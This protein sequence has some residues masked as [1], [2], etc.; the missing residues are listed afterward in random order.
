M[1]LR[2][3][4]WR[5]GDH[6]DT[7]AIIPARHCNTSDPAILAQHCM[8]DADPEFVT[9]MR[10]GDLIVAGLN[11]GCGSSREVA[12]IA[13]RAAG[14]SA[15]VAKSYARIFFRNAINIGLPILECPEAAE[16]IRQGDEIEVDTGRG[17]IRD[18]TTGADYQAAPF[19]EFLQRII[20]RGGLMP[21]IEEQL[22]ARAKNDPPTGDI[23]GSN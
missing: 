22:A 8:E 14:V 15:V 10:W 20:D 13:I 17:L 18:L 7:D 23:R 21:Y 16:G 9:K 12:P 3:K 2:G 5:F 4:A 6:V 11:F 1:I 19:P